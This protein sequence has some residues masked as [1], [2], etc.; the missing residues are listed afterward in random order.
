MLPRQPLFR[1]S[2]R[3]GAQFRSPVRSALQKRLNSTESQLPELP[4]NKFNA[5]R[6]AVKEHAAGT[7]GKWIVFA[8]NCPTH[9]LPRVLKELP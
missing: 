3:A 8:L 4:N 2:Q 1:L 9:S 6:A 7:S 5:E